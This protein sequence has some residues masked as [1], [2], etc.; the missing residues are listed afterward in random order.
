MTSLKTLA[1]TASTLLL[2]VAAGCA[3]SNDFDAG[4]AAEAATDALGT[5]SEALVATDT[6]DLDELDA[7]EVELLES[8]AAPN[9]G[10]G[11]G[12]GDTVG[13]CKSKCDTAYNDCMK[14]T[15]IRACANVRSRCK[16]RCGGTFALQ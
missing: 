4:D 12:G 3:A 6:F 14:G 2:A 16:T 5:V 7:E 8:L 1:L 11:T 15:D 10:T 9:T 13:T